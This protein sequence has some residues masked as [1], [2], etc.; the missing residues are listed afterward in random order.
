M[1]FVW[2]ENK[3]FV[4]DFLDPVLIMLRTMECENK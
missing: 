4:F 2:G 3:L 1:S